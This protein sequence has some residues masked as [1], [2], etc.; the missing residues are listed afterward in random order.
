MT[1][2]RKTAEGK[3]RRKKDARVQLT[4]DPIDR[5]AALGCD[6]IEIMAIFAMDEANDIK[7]RASMAKELASYVAPK[8]RAVEPE[9][10]FL[11][12]LAEILVKARKRANENGGRSAPG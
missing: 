2:K 1:G 10:N 8:R 4:R 3:V 11:G 12:D 7:L 5:L 6:P 9:G